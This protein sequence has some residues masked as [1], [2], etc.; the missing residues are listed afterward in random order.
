MYLYMYIYVYVYMY[1]YIDIYIY[2]HIFVYTQI[3]MGW[4]QLV[5]SLKLRSLLQYI[6]SFTGLFCKRDL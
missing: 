5:G 1:M 2:T 6:V 3:Y 4:L